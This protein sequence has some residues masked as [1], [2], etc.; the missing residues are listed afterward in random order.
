MKKKIVAVLLALSLLGTAAA[1]G[2]TKEDS[3]KEETKTEETAEEEFVLT[4]AAGNV[5]AVDEEKLEDYVTL[6]EYKNL[7]VS[8]SPKTEITDE[9]VDTNIQSQLLYQYDQV[10][11]TEDRGLQTNDTA[12]I[13]FTGY[14]DGEEFDGGSGEG[15]DLV[16]GSGSFIDGFEDGLIGHKKGEEVTLDLT[17]PENYQQEDLQGKAVQFKV[18]IN[19]IS[20]APELT[21]EWTAANT[22][23]KTVDEFKAAQKEQLQKDADNQYEGQVKSDLFTLVVDSTE[24]KE[25]PEKILEETKEDVR[26]Q[27][28]TLYAA[29]QGMTL[30]EYLE[31]QGISDEDAE[32]MITQSAQS[33]L[34][35]NLIVQA[36]FDAEGIKLTEQDYAEEKEKT[37]QL[38]GFADAE[39]M[40]NMYSDQKVVKDNV[41]WNKACDVMMETATITEAEETEETTG[42]E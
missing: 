12:N 13:D 28:E 33:Y 26:N 11:V 31:A 21:D 35:Q 9:D 19:K 15:Y 10:E 5:V 30:D 20:E 38:F 8:E 39:A 41:L 4:N 14:M 24:I 32:E 16:I 23:Y 22:D 34:K 7:E 25:Y 27:L 37:A 17:F 29:S 1:C 2:N 40:E 3:S 36:I 6:G 42:Q 18:K